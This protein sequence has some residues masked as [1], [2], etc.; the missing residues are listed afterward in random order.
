MSYLYF[1]VK[2]GAPMFED[3]HEVPVPAGQLCLMCRE[4][5]KREDSGVLM[6]YYGAKGAGTAPEHIECFLRSLLGNV[7]HLEKRCSCYDPDAPADSEDR[8]PYRQQARQTMEWL[9]FHR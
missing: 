8:R 9:V 5:I 4:V 2:W 1:G 6:P 7:R 3:A